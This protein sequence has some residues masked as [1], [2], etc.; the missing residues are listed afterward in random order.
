MIVNPLADIIIEADIKRAM[1]AVEEDIKAGKVWFLG[2]PARDDIPEDVKSMA[3]RM[4]IFLV[5]VQG[6][7]VSSRWN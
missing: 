6:K 1:S 5:A 4:A 7:G 3:H 2:L